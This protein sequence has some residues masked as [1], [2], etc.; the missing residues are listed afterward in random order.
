MDRLRAFFAL[1]LGGSSVRRALRIQDALRRGPGGDDLRWVREES[2]HVTLHFLGATERAELPGLL[3]AVGER[4]APLK[5]FALRLGAVMGLPSSHRPRVVA[6]GLE[7]EPPLAELAG[8]VE[9]GVCAAGR[10]PESRPFRPHVT[11]GRLRRGRRPPSELM[12]VTASVTEPDDAWE[13]REIVLF[14]S[15]LSPGGSRYTALEHMPLS[16]HP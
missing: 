10:E 9:R 1:E 3:A 16:V 15:R 6:L 8:A 4:L 12:S 13:V 2:L 14:Q 11:L 5:P 7:P